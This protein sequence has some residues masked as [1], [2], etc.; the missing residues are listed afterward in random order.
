MPAEMARAYLV[1]KVD[2]HDKERFEEYRAKAAS[3]LEHFGVE[4]VAA[5]DPAMQVEGQVGPRRT[6]I[7]GFD[8]LDAARAWHGSEQY[9]DALN[10]RKEIARSDVVLVEGRERPEDLTRALVTDVLT[11]RE[12]QDAGLLRNL[13]H[14]RVTYERPKSF[15]PE[16]VTGA[17][18]VAA[19]LAGG[20]AGQHLLVESIHRETHAL[21]VDGKRAIVLQ[22]MSA[23]TRSGD[24][25]T[26][27]YA[28]FYVRDGERITFVKEYADSFLAARAFGLAD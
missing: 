17:R 4:V 3:S 15:G 5:S 18:A 10:L 2:V 6:V 20:A 21:L 8:S 24:P 13:L 14:E 25:F 19:A 12:Q 7:L 23:V 22:T 9:A 27:E 1:F 11:A 28:W 26:N 16:P